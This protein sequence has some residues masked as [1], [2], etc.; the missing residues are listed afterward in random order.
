M[1]DRELYDRMLVNMLEFWGSDPDHS[2]RHDGVVGS[3]CPPLPH[4]AVLNSVAYTDTD[5][6]LAVLPELDR[7]YVEAGVKAWTVWTPAYDE[8]ARQGLEA[9]GHFLDSTPQSMAA[10][11]DEIDIGNGAEGLDWERADGVEEMCVVL[12]EAFG[13]E[14]EPAIEVMTGLEQISH[15]YIARVDGEAVA[16]VVA[17]HHGGDAG[18]Y[19]VGTRAAARGKGLATGLM[20]QAA[21]DAREA[22]CQTTSLQ[23]TAMGRPV[24][25]RLGYRD[26]GV[27]EMWEKRRP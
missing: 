26:L 20:R 19:N 6:L 1:E 21:R 25:Q 5:N 24:Y 12:G 18:I 2:L 10:P 16:T 23:A 15:V 8:K 13:W 17:Y 4:R 11:L 3:L 22:G 7:A 9:A 27:I 14:V